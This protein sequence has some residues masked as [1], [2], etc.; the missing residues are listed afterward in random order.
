MFVF[1]DE[2]LVG[3]LRKQEAHLNEFGAAMSRALYT[4]KRN[5]VVYVYE[6]RSIEGVLRR[7]GY[8]PEQTTFTSSSYQSQSVAELS[9]IRGGVLLWF[10]SIHRCIMPPETDHK[11]VRIHHRGILHRGILERCRVALCMLVAKTFTITMKT[12]M[13]KSIFMLSCGLGIIASSHTI[14][15]NAETQPLTN[16][17]SLGHCAVRLAAPFTQAPCALE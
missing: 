9:N 1:D 5:R 2:I 8:E 3:R 7:K 11:P 10:S 6:H 13:F 17:H 12:W 4:K 14:S 16:A 15:V